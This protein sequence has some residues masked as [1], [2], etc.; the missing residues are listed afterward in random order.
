MRILIADDERDISDALGTIFAYHGYKC[1][2]VYNG[3]DALS[4]SKS[5]VY[6]AILL[7]IMMPK[8]DGIEVLTHIREDGDFTPVVMLTAKGETT[9]K[10]QG[11]NDGADD[12]IAKPFDSGELIAR[13]NSAIRRRETY[14]GSLLTFENIAFDEKENRLYNRSSSLR[15]TGREARMIAFFMRNPGKPIS[16]T[17]LLERFWNGEAPKS[18]IVALY[19]GYIRNKLN[20]VSGNAD[21]ETDGNGNYCLVRRGD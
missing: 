17:M 9:D 20:S 5:T 14:S 3:A 10:I 16:E 11:L 7:D 18:G 12:Y 8:M 6:D 1:D 13:V 21:I 4:M 19:I 2:V 15:V